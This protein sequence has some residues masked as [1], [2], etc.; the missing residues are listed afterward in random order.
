MEDK[1]V[2][3]SYTYDGLDRLSSVT[4]DDGKAVAYSYDE[5]GS[6]V[7]VGTVSHPG[8]ETVSSGE[9]LE[10]PQSSPSWHLNRGGESFGPYSWEEMLTFAADGRIQPEDLVWNSNMTAWT[11]ARDVAGLITGV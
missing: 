8:T 3:I 2:T 5:A 9:A 10:T 4:Y 11:K 7:A 1:Q 6:L